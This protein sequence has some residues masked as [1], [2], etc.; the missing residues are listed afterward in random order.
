MNTAGTMA[1]AMNP[2]VVE[3]PR[4]MDGEYVPE[5]IAR[6]DSPAVEAPPGKVAPYSDVMRR[7]GA[8]AANVGANAAVMSAPTN[9]RIMSLESAVVMLAPA[10][11][12]VPVTVPG[13]AGSQGEAVFAFA[14]PKAM[15]VADP[16]TVVATVDTVTVVVVA[17]GWTAQN[18]YVTTSVT[19]RAGATVA[20]S[21][22]VSPGLLV[23]AD[24]V[25]RVPVSP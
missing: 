19:D 17:V 15:A 2:Q 7:E 23:T 14:T 11:V 6:K 18:S 16:A 8:T 3:G 24:A 22:Q 10:V 20:L 12:P 5:P 1:S 9:P 25:R 4:V 13:V 21:D